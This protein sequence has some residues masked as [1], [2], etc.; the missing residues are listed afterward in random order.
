MTNSLVSVHQEMSE[1]SPGADATSSPNTGWTVAKVALGNYSKLDSNVEQIS[2]TFATT[3]IEPDGSIDTTVGDCLRS[4]NTYNGDFANANWTFNCLVIAVTTGGDQDGNIGLRLFKGVAVNGSD[5]VEVT[6]A[7][8]EGAAV[9]NLTT[10]TAQNSNI[11]F[12]PGAFT[13]TNQ[14]LFLQLGWEI[15]GAGGANTRDVI[16]RIGGNSTRVITANFTPAAVT[17]DLATKVLQ[18]GGASELTPGMLQISG[19]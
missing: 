1:T 3:P 13:V 17:D 19:G 6:A 9:T 10:T 11:T 2:T 7:R 5:A 18:L 4:T 15:T 14:Y 12:N 8:Q 16:L